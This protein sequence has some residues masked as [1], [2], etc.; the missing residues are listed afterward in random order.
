MR[1]SSQIC[2][3]CQIRI[4]WSSNK[5]LFGANHLQL[6]RSGLSQQW[7]W[8]VGGSRAT[9]TVSPS[10][11][12]YSGVIMGA[13]ASLITS[14]H[15]CLLNCSSRRRSKNTSKLRVTGLCAGNSPGTGEFPAQMASNAGHAA[16]RFVLP[17]WTNIQVR[18]LYAILCS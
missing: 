18:M 12:H 13:K 8:Y 2:N 17:L 10:D 15:E 3:H 14:P 16:G 1:N 9:P 7:S 6:S 5:C 11:Y 4:Y